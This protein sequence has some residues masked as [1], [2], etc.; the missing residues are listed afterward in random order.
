VELRIG[1]IVEP[2][3]L[4]EETIM[5]QERVSGVKIN[6]TPNKSYE[7]HYKQSD[8]EVLFRRGDW[9]NWDEA[10]NWLKE[11][12]EADNEL[13]PGEVIAMKE[14]LEKLKKRGDKFTNDP[15]AVFRM[16]KGGGSA[17]H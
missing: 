9:H 16:V 2:G 1:L 6:E 14:D 8:M 7:R 10:I 17:T 15:A 3:R 5:S 12:G 4:K 11:D 13:T